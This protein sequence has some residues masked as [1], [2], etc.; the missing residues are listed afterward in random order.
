MKMYN[1]IVIFIIIKYYNFKI[2]S[3]E[4]LLNNIYNLNY[5]YYYNFNIY[6]LIII[7]Y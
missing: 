7:I 2:E 5:I 1:K 4:C 6:T 3:Y